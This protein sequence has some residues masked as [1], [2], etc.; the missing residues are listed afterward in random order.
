MPIRTVSRKQRS[1]PRTMSPDRKSTR[2]NSSHGYNSYA[3]FCL[4]NNTAVDGAIDRRRDPAVAL[5]QVLEVA[6]RGGTDAFGFAGRQRRQRRGRDASH[7]E[8]APDLPA[9]PAVEARRRRVQR[10]DHETLFV[11]PFDGTGEQ[12]GRDPT[13]TLV[14]T[15]RHR[16]HAPH[17]HPPAAEA[18]AARHDLGRAD[19]LRA[20]PRAQEVLHALGLPPRVLSLGRARKRLAAE[21]EDGV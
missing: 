7:A 11:H 21:R 5:A 12:T 13:A 19:E 4:T 14:G 16:R 15:Y 3:V 18:L 1:F 8:L 2:L 17:R 20:V 6:G 10:A 9:E